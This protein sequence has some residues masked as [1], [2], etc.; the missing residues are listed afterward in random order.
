[1]LKIFVYLKL[2]RKFVKVKTIRYA[3]ARLKA[4]NENR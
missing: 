1:M 3:K 2:S 4:N